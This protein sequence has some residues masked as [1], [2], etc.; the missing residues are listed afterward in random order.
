MGGDTH[1]LRHYASGNYDSPGEK[2]TMRLLNLGCADSHIVGALN[3]DI[4]E[5]ADQIV[6]LAVMWPWLTSTW[7]SVRAH[8]II[9]HIADKIHFMNEL[10][11]VMEDG[12]TVEIITPEAT[13]CGFW[14]DP[15]HKSGWVLNSFQYFQVGSFAHQRFAKAYWIK[16]AFE[17]VELGKKEYP[18]VVEPVVKITA[19][20]KAVK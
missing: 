17:I 19:V 16:A 20:L 11:R 18:D 6:D 7:S 4:C 5:P 14:Q 8:D 13:G 2:V 9:E 10:W 1:R 12:G 15:T 3:V